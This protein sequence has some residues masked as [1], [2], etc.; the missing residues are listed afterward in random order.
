MP[1]KNKLTVSKSGNEYSFSWQKSTEENGYEIYV[2]KN[3]GKSYSLLE[4]VYGDESAVSVT[5][6][7]SANLK[8]KMRS[9]K[10]IYPQ[11]FYSNYS[12][13][14]TAKNVTGNEES[15]ESGKQYSIR[16]KKVDKSLIIYNSGISEGDNLIL[17]TYLEYKS[18]K[19]YLEKLS[20][21]YYVIR[22]LYS[23]LV[24]G[25]EN[26]STKDGAN[27]AQY[28]YNGSQSQQWKIEN[29]NGYYKI[30]NC[31][32]GKALEVEG[33]NCYNGAN[34]SQN[35]YCGKDHQLWIIEAVE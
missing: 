14:V 26:S 28:N 31:K 23:N 7:S 30:I 20:N 34:I 25:V 24:L 15:F 12:A 35:E 19:W 18:Q 1:K 2:S 27:I 33:A 5:I 16:C 21:G 32:S 8:F 13:V 29:I 4:T 17:F 6:N 22:N 9:F 3:D 11:K 10:Q